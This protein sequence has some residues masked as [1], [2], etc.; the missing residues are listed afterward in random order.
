MSFAVREVNK[1]CPNDII[2]GSKYPSNLPE[3]LERD[4]YFKNE[5]KEIEGEFERDEVVVEV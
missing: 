5:L 1:I 2:I 3:V 4:V